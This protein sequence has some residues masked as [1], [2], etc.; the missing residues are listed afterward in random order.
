MEVADK[1]RSKSSE[2]GETMYT[3]YIWFNKWKTFN[4][5]ASFKEFKKEI[6]FNITHQ[7]W[8]S[9]QSLDFYKWQSLCI[10]NSEFNCF[11]SKRSGCL[12][13]KDKQ[14]SV[15]SCIFKSF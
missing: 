7:F 1:E 6:K 2:I 5:V 9:N 4:S 14:P 8:E 15:P 3:K 12:L 13:P 11:I 10:I